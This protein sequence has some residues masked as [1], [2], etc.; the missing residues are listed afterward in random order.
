MSSDVLGWDTPGSNL[1]AA[2]AT[3]TYAGLIPGCSAPYGVNLRP[4]TT[5]TVSLLESKYFISGAITNYA[6]G[7][8]IVPGVASPSY[9]VNL[10]FENLPDC[11][12]G[13]NAD[14][15]W[16]GENEYQNYLEWCG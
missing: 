4:D 9:D 16:R 14:S 8:P 2:T 7:P 3:G 12:L 11:F 15:Y 13:Q 1:V 10:L 5:P 6:A